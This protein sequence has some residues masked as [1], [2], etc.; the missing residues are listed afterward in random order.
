MNEAKSPPPTI[1][2]THFRFV[3]RNGVYN[4]AAE[5]SY[6]QSSNQPANFQ[7]A[8]AWCQTEIDYCPLVISIMSFVIITSFLTIIYLCAK[9]SFQCPSLRCC[10]LF[11]KLR[12]NQQHQHPNQRRR[13]LRPQSS[14]RV[15]VISGSVFSLN[16]STNYLNDSVSLHSINQQIDT[17]TTSTSGQQSTATVPQTTTMSPAPPPVPVSARARAIW[18]ITGGTFGKQTSDSAVSHPEHLVAPPSYDESQ[19]LH[20]MIKSKR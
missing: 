15:G 17:S 7:L 18:W 6:Q 2:I 20:G 11:A 16:T 14:E 4:P 9:T 19:Q 3:N 10:S 13:R 5:S 8:K 1:T 12:P